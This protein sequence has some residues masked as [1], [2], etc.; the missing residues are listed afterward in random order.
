L[1]RNYSPDDVNK[2]M[3]RNMLRVFL[4]VERASQEMR[5]PVNSR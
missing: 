4:A 1:D 2:I 3:G 5:T